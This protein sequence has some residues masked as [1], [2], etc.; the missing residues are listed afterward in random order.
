MLPGWAQAF[1]KAKRQNIAGESLPPAS[2]LTSSLRFHQ[3]A[4]LRIPKPRML[5]TI[6]SNTQVV[7][8]MRMKQRMPLLLRVKPERLEEV[9]APLRISRCL[10]SVA[11]LPIG[12]YID[13]RRTDSN[14]P[15]FGACL[16]SKTGSGQWTLTSA[17]ISRPLTPIPSWAKWPC[18]LHAVAKAIQAHAD[19][20]GRNK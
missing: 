7:N 19:S 17:K 6:L 5:T 18:L 20:L 13:L 14:S 4:T 12:H 3:L 2:V 11:D 9:V 10:I 15:C 8:L 1:D 16:S